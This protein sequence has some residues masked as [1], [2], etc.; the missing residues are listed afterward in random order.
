MVTGTKTT[1]TKGYKKVKGTLI[2]EGHELTITNPDKP[3]WPEAQIT[4]L[5]YLQNLLQLAPYLLRY[6]RNRHLTTIRFPHGY[7]DKSF[8]QKNAPEPVPDFVNLAPLS[9]INYVNLDSL[10]TLI[11]LGN[12]A[13]LEFH[14]SFHYIGE[15][16]PAEWVID[17]DPSLEEEPRIMLAAQLIGE[18]LEA[19]HIQ[20]VPKTSG[21]T[22]VQ[23][24]IPIQRGYSFDQLRKLGHFIGSYA[25]NKYPRLFTI[26][27]FKKNRGDLIY[28]DYLQHAYGKT[29]SAP[30]TPRARKDATISTPLLWK[31]VALNPSPREFN[32]HTIIDRLNSMGDL[33]DQTPLQNL[34]FVLE[35]IGAK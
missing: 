34:D 1:G 9:G 30:Y 27:R 3:L 14:P 2:I 10:P 21:A 6:C 19:M 4:K 22:G 8:Y 11:W 23:I 31:E 7:G 35:H 18:A 24:Y 25:V 16:T 32:Q 15:T 29:L 20:S 33:I 5:D 12:L 17:I 26:E 13:C 28:I